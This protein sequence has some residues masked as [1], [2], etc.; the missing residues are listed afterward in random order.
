MGTIIPRKAKDGSTRYRAQIR[1]TKAGELVH[2]ESDTFS[3]RALAKSWLARREAELEKPGAISA[4]RHKVTIREILT[5]HREATEDAF[6]K[7]KAAHIKQMESMPLAD[8]DAVGL[9]TQQLMAHITDRRKDAGPATVANDLIWLRVAFR[10]AKHAI[11]VPLSLEVIDEAAEAARHARLIAKPKRRDRR[12]TPEEL[13]KLDAHFAKQR[14]RKDGSTPNM[15]LVM[16]FAIYSARRQAEIVSLRIEDMDEAS[17]TYLARD[18]KHPDGSEGNHKHALLPPVGWIV[19][20]LSI[21]DRK[22][23]RVFPWSEDAIQRRFQDACKILQIRDLRFHDLRHEALSRL[24]EDGAT[25]PQI[26]QVSLHESWNSLQ[27]YVNV[28]AKRL[29]RVDFTPPAANP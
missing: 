22:E 9:T 10:W 19:A 24:A 11:G 18:L 3:T 6:G 1:I 15:R 5:K 13:E 16:W 21:G 20:K 17:G 25:I 29:R 26:Q 27:I 12:P 28:P 2:Q 8:L 7:T 14:F 23:G 4:T